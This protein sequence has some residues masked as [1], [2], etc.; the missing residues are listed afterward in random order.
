MPFE[1]LIVHVFFMLDGI[2]ATC[3]GSCTVTSVHV[4]NPVT[5]VWMVCL[6]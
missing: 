1:G 6:L 5:S 3:L 4:L 2:S